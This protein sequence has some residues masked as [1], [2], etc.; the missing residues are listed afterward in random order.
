MFHEIDEARVG[1]QAEAMTGAIAACVHCGFCL[2]ACPTY[3]ADGQEADSPRGRIYL[4]KGALEGGLPLEDVLPHVDRCLGCLGCVT[5]CPSGV[6]YGDL[7]TPF[8]AWAAPRRRRPLA[9]RLQRAI[10]LKTLPYPRRFRLSVRLGR[11]AKPLAWAAPKSLRAMIDLL[12]D[13]LP[14]AEPLPEVFPA[15]GRR[16]ARVALLAGCAQ[17]VLAPEIN[18]ATLRV[19]AREGVE[20]IVPAGQ[21]CCGAL[22]AHT[23][24]LPLAKRLAKQ[25]L[26]TLPTDVD[27]VIT[28]AA[29]CGSGMHEYPLWFAGDSEQLAAEKLAPKVQDVC[30]F[31]D[32]LGASTEARLPSPTR[33]AYHDACHLAHAQKVRS[34]PRRLLNRIENLELV[35]IRDGDVCCGSAGSYNLEQPEMAARL[36]SEKAAAVLAAGA[37]YVAMGNIGCMTQLEAHLQAASSAAAA[38]QSSPPKVAHTIQLLDRAMG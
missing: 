10:M 38:P 9:Q 24:D 25:N 12:P 14:E 33:V 4:M 18:W 1:P 11:L 15:V 21:G 20:V 19:L 3:R 28:N 29:G 27:A 16:R 5:A 7:V 37:E 26:A 23:G 36:G 2:P 35:E 17:Q 8:R 13:N 30:Q 31:I 22:A 32:E 6:Q 34:A